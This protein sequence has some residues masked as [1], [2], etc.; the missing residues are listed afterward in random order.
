MYPTLDLFLDILSLRLFSIFVP[1]VLLDRHNYGTA[2]LSVGWQTHPSLEAL[3][4][5]W[6]CALQVLSLHSRA[7]HLRS[8]PLSPESLS[9]PRFLVYSGVSSHLLHPKVACFYS[10]FWPS[11]L[12]FCPNSSHT[13]TQYM[14]TYV[15]EKQRYKK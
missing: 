1:S 9:P 3:S 15:L 2:F 11:G 14:V 6:R 10:F 5:Y 7:F 12:Q 13:H 4:F 8:F